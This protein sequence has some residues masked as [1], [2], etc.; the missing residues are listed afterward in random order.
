MSKE[1]YNQIID[2]VYDNYKKEIIRQR[3]AQKNHVEK[4]RSQGKRLKVTRIELLTKEEFINKCKTDSEFSEKWVL[5]IE[6]RELSLFEK[7]TLYST[8]TGQKDWKERVECTI[9]NLGEEKLNKEFEKHKIPTKLITLTYNNET[10][11]SYELK[12]LQ[13][14]EKNFRE[15]RPI[16]S[17]IFPDDD[18]K[19]ITIEEGLVNK[20]IKPKWYQKLMGAFKNRKL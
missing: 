4:L 16:I 13:L 5:K 12:T 20:I 7:T 17:H 3:E 10:I 2:E 8:K 19:Y 6:E 18:L 1:R 9:G 11:E 14:L 15:N